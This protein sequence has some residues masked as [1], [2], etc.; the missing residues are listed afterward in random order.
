MYTT[1]ALVSNYLQRDLS[2]HEQALLVSI[3]PAVKTLIDSYTG[4]SFSSEAASTRYYDGGSS[5]ISIDP[6]SNVTSINLVNDDLTDGEAYTD[7]SSY[8]LLPANETYKTEIL[9]RYGKFPRGVNRIKV[10]GT[11]GYYEDGVPENI[12]LAAT[13][14]AAN[15]LTSSNNS[16]NIESESIEGHTVKYSSDTTDL[17]GIEDPMVKTLLSPY[18]ELLVD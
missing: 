18:R 5:S 9:K 2:E 11:F 13:R 14:M 15:I 10:T 1:L 3:I 6:V 7:N 8:I 17:T 16:E 12:R 4:S